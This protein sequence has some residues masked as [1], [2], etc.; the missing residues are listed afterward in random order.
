MCTYHVFATHDEQLKV[1]EMQRQS[2]LYSRKYPAN[3]GDRTYDIKFDDPVVIETFRLST[4]PGTR[5]GKWR[6]HFLVGEGSSAPKLR[7]YY[8]MNPPEKK[9]LFEGQ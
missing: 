3:N 1:V 6:F 4:N 2:K 7:L 9:L 8:R 5:R